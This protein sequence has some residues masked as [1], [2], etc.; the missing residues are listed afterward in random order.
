MRTTVSNI[1]WPP[2]RADEIAPRLIELGVEHVEIAP[3]TRWD[4]PSEPAKPEVLQYRD[5]WAARGITI[6]S[7]QALLYGRPDLTI[8]DG[9]ETREQ[10]LAYLSKLCRLGGWLGATAL[11]FGSPKNR[12]RRSLSH[13]QAVEIASEFFGSLALVAAS[14]NTTVCI[15]PNPVDY[16]ADF[17]L[18]AADAAEIV[19]QVDH[20]GVRLH[21]DTACM[22][23]AGDRPAEAI[24]RH[25][26]ILGHV[27]ISEPQ[28]G[29]VGGGPTD[30]PHAETAE[31]LKS[32]GYDGF[33]SIEMRAGAEPIGSVE[34]AIRFVADRYPAA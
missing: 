9:E 19:R 12:R 17:I 4:D 20:P 34:Q 5:W 30:T 24:R 3:T 16:G 7:M 25:S 1:A 26:D 21:L 10:T 23:L 14:H 2:E 32:A 33:I 27:H 18:N 11:V 15:E 28:L 8:F 22:Y 13:N 29:P 31:A 6:S